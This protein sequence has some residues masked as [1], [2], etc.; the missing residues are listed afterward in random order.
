MRFGNRESGIG[1]RESGF[2]FSCI[3]YANFTSRGSL[4]PVFSTLIAVRHAWGVYGK[5]VPRTGPHPV[6]SRG[7]SPRLIWYREA[8]PYFFAFKKSKRVSRSDSLLIR[9][10]KGD[11]RWPAK[12]EG[13]RAKGESIPTNLSK[14]QVELYNLWR[15]V[16]VFTEM[17]SI[18]TQKWRIA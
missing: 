4:F 2:A 10:L 17:Y 1:N 18:L 14:C 6:V 15:Q 16:S 5:G 8:I 13:R 11:N 7:V 12:G 9:I 3:F